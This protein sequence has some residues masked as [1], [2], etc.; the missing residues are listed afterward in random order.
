MIEIRFGD[1]TFTDKDIQ[2]KANIYRTISL[3]SR[4]LEYDVF[5]F[6]V[7]ASAIGEQKLF[8]ILHEWVTTVDGKGFVIDSGDFEE[9]V[10]NAPLYIYENGVQ[11]ALFYV[12]DI[13]PTGRRDEG[14]EFFAVSC[15]SEIAVLSKMT[16]AGGVYSGTKASVIIADIMGT[17]P[18]EID[19]DVGNVPLYG[20]LPYSTDARDNLERVLFALGAN[21]MRTSTGVLRF[22]YNSNTEGAIKQITKDRIFRAFGKKEKERFGKVTVVEHGFYQSSLS[23]EEVILDNS[24]ETASGERLYI[25]DSPHYGYRGTGGIQVNSSGANWARIT[26]TGQI[27]AKPYIHT[28]RPV[29]T[30]VGEG[31]LT[32]ELVIEDETLVSFANVENVVAR[33]ATYYGSSV[34]ENV[35][36]IV[37]DEKPGDLVGFTDYRGNS[38]AGY[39]QDL[40]ETASSFWRGRAKVVTN[41]TPTGGG[42]NFSLSQQLTGSGTWRKADA[43]AL[44]GHPISVVRFDLIGAGNGGYAGS[45]GEAGASRKGGKGGDAGAGGECGEV[46]SVTLEGDEIPDTITFACG[47]GGE[48]GMAG[49]ATTLTVD[50][51]TYSSREGARP[52]AGYIDLFTG[53]IRCLNGP[54]GVAGGDG[55]VYSNFDNFTVEELRGGSVTYKSRTWNAG[56][57]GDYQAHWRYTYVKDDHGRWVQ[58][59]KPTAVIGA[60]SSTGGAAFGAN[61]ADGT[62]GRLGMSEAYGTTWIGVYDAYSGTSTAG[63]DALPIDDY[64]PSYGSGGAGGNGGGG[65]GSKNASQG[66]G[67]YR[68]LSIDDVMKPITGTNYPGNAGPGG[69]GSDGTR[70]GDGMVNVYI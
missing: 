29:S 69:K 27:Y 43:E 36:F 33:L 10:P 37:N 31:V 60:P 45:D 16:H 26:G 62:D 58:Q 52:V 34:V 11:K 19:S 40:D 41:W 65:G 57:P 48:P 15:H 64:T 56:T 59:G 30:S 66:A 3:L 6:I 49:S 20:W 4:G 42:N 28:Q 1:Y 55:G 50:E 38:K 2:T 13:E 35:D 63:A 47:T 21:A 53:V 25:F 54:S 46:F 7:K 12:Y 18:Y 32:D 23:T 67:G 61:S 68:Y 24:S 17:L 51:T 5:D 9:F 22:A 44:V 39:I 8:T 14:D 70:G